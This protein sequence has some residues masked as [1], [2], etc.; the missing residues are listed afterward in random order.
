MKG[1]WTHREKEEQT[2]EQRPQNNNEVEMRA[3]TECEAFF[4][5]SLGRRGSDKGF[6]YIV[7]SLFLRG[8]AQ[9]E[10]I[11][12]WVI[13]VYLKK[14]PYT[15]FYKQLSCLAPRLR[16]CIY[17][18]TAKQLL[19]LRLRLPKTHQSNILVEL[20]AEFPNFKK[21]EATQKWSCL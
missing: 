9:W 17:Q 7:K 1:D 10:V 21:L 11:S 19:S 8:S 12:D 20:L 5:S 3:V 15:Y 18:A 6:Y 13:F 2:V 14:R 16:F 4:L